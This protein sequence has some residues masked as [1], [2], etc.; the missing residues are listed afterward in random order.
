MALPRKHNLEQLKKLRLITK[1]NDIGDKINH[2]N[3]KYPNGY[4]IDNPFDR[5]IDTYESFIKSDNKIKI[6]ESTTFEEDALIIWENYYINNFDIIN[7]NHDNIDYIV[8]DI[9][10]KNQYKENIEFMKDDL[11][12]IISNYM[13]I[14]YVSES[15]YN[16]GVGPTNN[17]LFIT[18]T[19]KQSLTTSISTDSF[20]VGK[21]INVGKIKGFIDSIDNKYLYI[22]E[23]GTEKKKVLITDYIKELSKV[24][25]INEKSG[26]YSEYWDELEKPS[27]KMSNYHREVDVIDND[28]MIDNDGYDIRYD[29]EITDIDNDYDNEMTDIDN[30]YDDEITDKDF[31]NEMT[32]L[33]NDIMTNN[34][35]RFPNPRRYSPG[36]I[37]RK[38]NDVP[39]NI[40]YE[41]PIRRKSMRYDSDNVQENIYINDTKKIMC[42]DC[43]QMVMDDYKSKVSHI[44][45]KHFNK[46]EMDGAVP[47][48]DYTNSLVSWPQGGKQVQK[49]IRKY[50]FKG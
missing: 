43:G 36:R 47:Y 45:N 3:K 10:E 27:N 40:P 49:L 32:E 17:S 23:E 41:M 4:V 38:S 8:N 2:N 35:R 1:N 29:N 13:D 26:L 48:K 37:N 21:Y 18:P 7:N 11:Y 39:N 16:R 34:I 42:N 30:D 33:D 20:N 9:I 12:N 50:F 19:P 28:E 24:K 46:P 6:T 25:T 14:E 15:V 22:S 44:Y 5:K 31:D